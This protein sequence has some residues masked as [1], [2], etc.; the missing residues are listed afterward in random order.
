MSQYVKL[1][2]LLNKAKGDRSLNQFASCCKVDA[3]HLSRVLRGRMVNAPS[4]ETLKK[5]A[6][7]AQNRVTYEEL[8]LAAGHLVKKFVGSNIKLL[9]GEKSYEEYSLYLKMQVNISISPMLL[10][11]YEKGLEQPEDVIVEHIA[12]AERLEPQFFYQENIPDAIT[13]MRLPEIREETVK[14]HGK[15]FSFMEDEI[16]RWLQNNE[17]YPYIG[18]A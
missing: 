17:N 3:G 11:R 5:I 10:E 1:I 4:P 12:K 16:A 8:M 2:E 15:P 13:A 9:R 7:N 18:L 14:P 6:E